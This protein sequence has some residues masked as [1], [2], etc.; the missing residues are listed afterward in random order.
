MLRIK[1]AKEEIYFLQEFKLNCYACRDKMWVK[2]DSNEIDLR[3][4]EEELD[5]NST[6][7]LLVFFTPKNVLKWERK[8]LSSLLVL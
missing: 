2:K 5:S 7:S 6:I 3:N 4:F 8:K 1:N